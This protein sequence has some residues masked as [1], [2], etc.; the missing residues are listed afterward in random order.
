MRDGKV[1]GGWLGQ[2]MGRGGSAVLT[3]VVR[4]GTDK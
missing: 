2:L 1:A 3:K 4:E